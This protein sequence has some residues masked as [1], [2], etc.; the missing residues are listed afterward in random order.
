M[1]DIRPEDKDI[2]DAYPTTTAQRTKVE[3]ML[4]KGYIITRTFEDRIEICK[5]TTY[6]V[7]DAEGVCWSV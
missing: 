6:Y 1:A 2:L 5:T 4:C 3:E 7:I